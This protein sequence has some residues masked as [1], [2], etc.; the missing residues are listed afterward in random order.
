MST[1]SAMKCMALR[2]WRL[3]FG[4][5]GGVAPV[6]KHQVAEESCRERLS[7]YSLSIPEPKL[8]FVK[9]TYHIVPRAS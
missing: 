7:D 6:E 8:Q 2:N 3:E 9:L 1:Y 5:D 4:G